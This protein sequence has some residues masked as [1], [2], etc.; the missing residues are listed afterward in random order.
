MNY[1]IWVFCFEIVEIYMLKNQ[2]IKNNNMFYVLSIEIYN[3][4]TVVMF[5]EVT[6]LL[7]RCPRRLYDALRREV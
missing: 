4:E 1:A 2:I 7:E 6:V 3:I 5:G